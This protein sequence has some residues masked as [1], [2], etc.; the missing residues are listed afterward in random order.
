MSRLFSHHTHIVAVAVAVAMSR[1]HFFSPGLVKPL[2]IPTDAPCEAEGRQRRGRGKRG[3]VRTKRE[4]RSRA[5][6]CGVFL[7]SRMGRFCG[8]CLPC[9][10]FGLSGSSNRC[11]PLKGGARLLS[12]FKP[13]DTHGGVFW[14]F[15]LS[16]KGARLRVFRDDVSERNCGPRLLA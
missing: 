13:R 10:V 8:C 14:V 12:S 9:Q 1:R 4:P 7:A 6:V 3:W 2:S 16:A 15:I 11:D 5:S